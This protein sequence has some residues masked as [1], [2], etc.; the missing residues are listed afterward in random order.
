MNEIFSNNI[1]I[2]LLA[3]I[4][5]LATFFGVFLGNFGR[6]TKPKIV[7]GSSFAAGIMILI[8][9]FELIPE[10]EKEIGNSSFIWATIGFCS[11]LLINQVLPHIHTLKGIDN[12]NE[13]CMRKMSYL[14]AIGMILHDFPEGFAISSSFGASSKLGLILVISTFIHNIPEGYILA[15]AS[16][17]KKNINFSY[18]SALF[19]SIATLLGALLG[20]LLSNIFTNINPYFLAFAGGAMIFISTSELIPTS[21]R[22]G[23]R[24][25]FRIGIATSLAL[26]ITLNF[27]I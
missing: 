2:L 7:F 21:L 4:S 26:F 12:C 24:K 1:N 9:F 20:I 10:A 25:T 22:N 15:I 14:L 18:I 3:A 16:S 11:I 19:S 5:G 13:R 27:A 17:K 8:S 6:K 23:H